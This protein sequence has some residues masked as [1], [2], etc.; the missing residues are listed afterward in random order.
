MGLIF[1][2]LCVSHFITILTKCSDILIG[3]L[4]QSPSLIL[5]GNQ[6]EANLLLFTE[7]HRASQLV[8]MTL[9]KGVLE[10]LFCSVS[11]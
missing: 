9:K 8:F 2:A 5:N 11:T 4:Y 7:N 3:L 10:K 6:M 1:C